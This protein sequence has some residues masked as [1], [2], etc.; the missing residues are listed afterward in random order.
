[1]FVDLEPSLDLNLASPSVIIAHD[2]IR[3][4]NRAI[5]RTATLIRKAAGVR[6]RQRVG[7]EGNEGCDEL[8]V[9]FFKRAAKRSGILFCALHSMVIIQPWGS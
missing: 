1:M 2:V 6:R 4:S 3:T 5:G 8:V 7:G 9:N